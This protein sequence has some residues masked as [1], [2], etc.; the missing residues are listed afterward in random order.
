MT[1]KL[2][3]FS[4]GGE[5]K[6]RSFVEQSK[7]LNFSLGVTRRDW[8][9]NKDKARDWGGLDMKRGDSERC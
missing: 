5:K 2:W 1:C 9:K 3:D 6:R 7:M 8:V 4:G